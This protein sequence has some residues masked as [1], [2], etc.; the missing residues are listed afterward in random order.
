MPELEGPELDGRE[1]QGKVAIITGAGRMRS[2]GHAAA[3]AFAEKGADVVVT[4]TGRDASTYPADE[5][6]AGWKDVESVAEGVRRLGRRALAMNVDVSSGEQVQKMVDRTVGELGRID[7]LINN[8]GAGRTVGLKPVAELPED[9]WR[10]VIDIKLT[11]T[12]LCTRA[13]LQVMLQQGEGG[14]IV[15]ISSV[16][17]KLTR[18]NGSA[19][20]TASGALYPF[21]AIVAKEVA[22]Q[23][24]RVNCISPGTTDTS[25]NDSLYGYPRGEVWEQRV[26]SIP[27]GR[28]GTPEE[29]ANVI[30]WLCSRD[31]CFIVGQCIELDGGQSA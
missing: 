18:P 30:T 5:I 22:S 11:G 7:F 27:L 20:A 4:G 14:S 15:N 28:A 29:I 17:A 1:F 6:A 13:A 10:Q 8:A 2:I 19:Y 21:T 16:E 25:R 12:F 26:K 24:I 3:L 23:G 9:E 31:A